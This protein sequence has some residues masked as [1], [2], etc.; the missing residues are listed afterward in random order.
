MV[1]INKS[2]L[3]IRAGKKELNGLVPIIVWYSSFDIHLGMYGTF[4]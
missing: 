2:L 3:E 4:F 1:V